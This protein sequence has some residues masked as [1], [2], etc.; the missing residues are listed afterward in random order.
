LV[1]SAVSESPPPKG[2]RKLVGIWRVASSPLLQTN[3][4]MLYF[5]TTVDFCDYYRHYQIGNLSSNHVVR[6]LG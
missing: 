6:L 5:I 4:G 3:V 1:R 2:K